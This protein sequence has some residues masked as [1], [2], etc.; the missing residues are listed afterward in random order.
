[1]YNEFNVNDKESCQNDKETIH[2][3]GE[4]GGAA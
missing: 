4:A 1:M 2:N 3:G